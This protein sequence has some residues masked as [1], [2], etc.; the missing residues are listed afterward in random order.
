MTAARDAAVRMTV[1]QGP[2][3]ER[4]HGVAQDHIGKLGTFPV[5]LLQERICV[6][7]GGVPPAMEVTG[8]ISRS[9]GAAMAHVVFAYHQKALPVQKAGKGIVSGQHTRRCR[10]PAAPRPGAGPGAST[11][12]S[13]CAPCHGRE[14]KTRSWDHSTTSYP[15][16]TMACRRA[17]ESALPVTVTCLASRSATA[18]WTP[19]TA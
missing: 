2:G 11:A 3:Q 13:E 17:A 7:H 18:S 9:Q 6:V 4:T 15:A 19:G 1:Q 14:G 5:G 12:R 8:G 16:S 10:G